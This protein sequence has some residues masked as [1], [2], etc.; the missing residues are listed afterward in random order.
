MDIA[1]HLLKIL[2]CG[3]KPQPVYTAAAVA[4]TPLPIALTFLFSPSSVAS[5][6]QE[7]GA[8]MSLQQLRFMSGPSEATRNTANNTITGQNNPAINSWYR[9]S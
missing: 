6:L 3:F 2:P 5:C 7:A 4:L 1:K 8:A 9:R